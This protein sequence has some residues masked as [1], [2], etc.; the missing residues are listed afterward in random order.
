M[1]HT[2]F[3][4]NDGG[5]LAAG[6]RGAA[7]DCVTRAITIATGGDYR[8]VYDELFARGRDLAETGRSRAARRLKS[9]GATPRNGTLRKVYEPYL[10]DRGWVWTPTMHIGQGCTVHLRRDELPAVTLIARVS[11][12]LVAIVDGTA[13]D[14]PDPARGG[15]R[16]VYGYYQPPPGGIFSDNPNAAIAALATELAAT[17]GSI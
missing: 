7:G 15:S 5:R 2:G 14:T 11:R 12:H 9:R 17:G 8:A 4:Y 16:C 3:V 13:Y 6:F 1:N 10:I